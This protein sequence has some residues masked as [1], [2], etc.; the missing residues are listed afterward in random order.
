MWNIHSDFSK[1]NIVT[2]MS[3]ENSINNF[4]LYC[5]EELTFVQQKQ[6]KDVVATF[7]QVISETRLELTKL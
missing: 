5:L 6:M 4:Y 7:Q 1:S 3:S 2:S